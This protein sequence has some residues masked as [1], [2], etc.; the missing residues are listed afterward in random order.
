MICAD[1]RYEF[2]DFVE[3]LSGENAGELGV[4]SKV[5][6]NRYAVKNAAGHRGWF[7]STELR[8][9]EETLQREAELH[10]TEQ[11]R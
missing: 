2:G 8:H 7:F 3:I 1:H 6:L 4:V 9:V 11:K 10:G 5:V